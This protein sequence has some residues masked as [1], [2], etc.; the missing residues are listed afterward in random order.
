MLAACALALLA[1]AFA[2][3]EVLALAL[4]LAVAFLPGDEVPGWAPISACP[5]TLLADEVV[6][7]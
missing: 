2:G 4:V 7:G 5:W 1:D 6:T 3:A